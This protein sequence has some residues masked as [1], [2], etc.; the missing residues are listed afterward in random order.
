MVPITAARL[1][2]MYIVIGYSNMFNLVGT[3]SDDNMLQIEIIEQ[4]VAMGD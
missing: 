4:I 3:H 1:S 2:I